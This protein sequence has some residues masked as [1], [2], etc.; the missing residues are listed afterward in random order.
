MCLYSELF[1][2]LER[3]ILVPELC[4][5]I[6]AT[7]SSLPPHSLYIV[8]RVCTLYSLSLHS[9]FLHLFF[10]FLIFTFFLLFF[11]RRCNRISR[12][13]FRQFV[14]SKDSHRIVRI[15]VH[16]FVCKYPLPLCSFVF[17]IWIVPFAIVLL[18]ALVFMFPLLEII[19][20]TFATQVIGNS[21]FVSQIPLIGF[22]IP[23]VFLFC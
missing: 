14:K 21:I 4:E 16:F 22:V 6:V 18:F 13:S 17:S 1:F 19:H 2:H 12:F 5:Y 23:M 15:I 9:F 3:E 7:I 8:F 20:I 11:S 10:S